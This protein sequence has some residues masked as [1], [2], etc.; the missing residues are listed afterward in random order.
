MLGLQTDTAQSR[1]AAA[2]FRVWGRNGSIIVAFTVEL[3]L[4][5]SYNN[6]K[7]NYFFEVI[8]VL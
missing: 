3:Y 7:C 4:T 2:R 1:D 8:R 5:I 6:N